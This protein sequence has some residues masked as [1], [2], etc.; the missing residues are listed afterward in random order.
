M[1]LKCK[2]KFVSWEDNRKL[3]T[4]VVKTA[5]ITSKECVIKTITGK[6]EAIESKYLQINK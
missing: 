4:C 6:R 5:T 3:Y 1:E 2:F